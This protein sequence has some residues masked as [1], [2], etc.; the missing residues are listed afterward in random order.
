MAQ[1]HTPGPQKGESK[2]ISKMLPEETV[3]RPVLF[4]LAVILSFINPPSFLIIPSMSPSPLILEAVFLQVQ[5]FP[6]AL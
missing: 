5:N 6:E 4:M 2:E 1:K 3:P